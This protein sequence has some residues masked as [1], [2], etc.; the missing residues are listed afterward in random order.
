MQAV[1]A[2]PTAPGHLDGSANDRYAGVN[3][4][5]SDGRTAARHEAALQMAPHHSDTPSYVVAFN[6]A[7]TVAMDILTLSAPANKVLRLRRVVIVNP[8]SA[9][10]AILVDL[11]LGIATA[12][13]SGGAAATANLLDGDARVVGVT[14]GPDAAFTGTCRSGDTVQATGFVGL[15]SPLDTLSVP[16]AAGATGPFTV[17][18]I[19][20][21]VC[22]PLTV[23]SAQ[24]IVLRTPAV[25]AGA[26]N[27]RG[28]A[29]FTVDDA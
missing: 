23:A 18:T 17:Y 2:N 4:V 22:K 7:A 12:V 21:G 9:T 28:Y 8:G 1:I 26:A 3:T 11:A 14:G 5:R 27:L 19:P 25:G 10:A 20:D 16:A 15:Y 24:F 29:E 6:V 13:G